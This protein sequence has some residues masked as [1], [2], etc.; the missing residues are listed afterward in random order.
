[1]HRILSLLILSMFFVEELFHRRLGK[2][3][4]LSST[5]KNYYVLKNTFDRFD[6]IRL[7][8]LLFLGL[9]FSTSEGNP[10]TGHGQLGMVLIGLQISRLFGRRVLSRWS[11]L[12]ILQLLEAVL[13][14][15]VILIPVNIP[16]EGHLYPFSPK[17]LLGLL[18]GVLYGVF[19]TIVTAFSI[20]YW[21]RHFTKEHGKLYHT[22]PPLVESESW[23]LK[24]S[25]ISLYL[26]TAGA[27]GLFFIKGLAVLPAVFSASLICQLAG[28]LVCKKETYNGHH[29]VAHILWM[30]SVLLLS[31][32][33]VS[34][35]TTFGSTLS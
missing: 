12:G 26:G 35:I 20:S 7:L 1:M 15:T 2:T 28:V 13:L 3:G 24:F 23:A 8:E 25:T 22:F 33:A 21:I 4:R 27:T 9:L 18:G 31:F 5:P 29:P 6:L 11:V 34:G 30:L 14:I 32:I 10:A 17:L 19:I 16:A